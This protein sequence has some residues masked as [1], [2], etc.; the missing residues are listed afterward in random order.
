MI[1][2]GH[3]SRDRERAVPLENPHVRAWG[4]VG[5]TARLRSR[6]GSSLGALLV[7]HA[8]PQQRPQESRLGS[9]FGAL[10]EEPLAHGRGSVVGAGHP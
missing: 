5:G 6:L 3:P 4:Y 7:H 9:S 8:R 2:Y 10:M 1:R